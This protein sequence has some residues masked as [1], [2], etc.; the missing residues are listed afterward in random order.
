LRIRQTSQVIEMGTQSDVLAGLLVDR[1]QQIRDQEMEIALLKDSIQMNGPAKYA[2]VARTIGEKYHTTIEEIAITENTFF[3]PRTK[4]HQMILTVY[5]KWHGP[6]NEEVRSEL[7]TWVP[8]LLGVE[9]VRI[10][11]E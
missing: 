6:E 10:I 3:N 1:E 8:V 5:V 7:S 11:S 4:S 9:E 2:E